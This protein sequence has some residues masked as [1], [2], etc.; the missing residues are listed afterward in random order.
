ME[1]SISLCW[2]L[3]AFSV[4]VVLSYYHLCFVFLCFCFPEVHV[5][6]AYGKDSDSLAYDL[7][8]LSIQWGLIYET[9]VIG[10]LNT[11]KFLY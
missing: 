9:K 4:S 5:F 7:T 6:N 8:F 10:S 3:G 2:Q 1:P 11:E